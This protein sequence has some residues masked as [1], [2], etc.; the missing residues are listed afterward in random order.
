MIAYRIVVNGAVLATIGQPDMSILSA[1]VVSSSGN[2]PLGQSDDIRLDLGGLSHEVSEGYPEHFR[3]K[4]R[5]LDIGDTVE[6]HVVDV[7]EVDTPA[8]R[9]RSDNRVQENPFTDD[10][11][12]AMRYADYLE[13]RKEFGD[14]DGT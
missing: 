8:K 14:A 12:R 13:L 1:T 2:S 5:S 7:D 4:T 9:F 10:E 11:M 6:I 3:W